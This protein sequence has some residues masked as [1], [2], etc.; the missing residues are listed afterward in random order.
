MI[1]SAVPTPFL[2]WFRKSLCPI[3]ICHGDSAINPVSVPVSKSCSPRASP[4]SSW[5][6]PWSGRASLHKGFRARWF[7]DSKSSSQ[8]VGNPLHLPFPLNILRSIQFSISLPTHGRCDSFSNSNSGHRLIQNIIR[9]I[10][11]FL[12]G[13]VELS[14]QGILRE[15]IHWFKIEIS[16]GQKSSTCWIIC[17]WDFQRPIQISSIPQSIFWNDSFSCST[18]DS[19]LIQW[20]MR[21]L[22]TG[23]I[24]YSK[25]IQKSQHNGRLSSRVE[26]LLATGLAPLHAELLDFLR[27]QVDLRA[28]DKGTCREPVEWIPGDLIW[29][30]QNWKSLPNPTSHASPESFPRRMV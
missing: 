11:N 5:L 21:M 17:Q 26:V 20:I 15:V 12:R 18:S 25:S 7:I 23:F 3:S 29:W 8:S 9:W 19:W 4:Q 10:V 6:S 13:Q 30:T 2:G 22:Q 28:S 27:G 1:H 16:T 24:L 14:A